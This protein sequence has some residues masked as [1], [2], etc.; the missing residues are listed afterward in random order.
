MRTWRGRH[1]SC[2]QH[3][4]LALYHAI[5]QTYRAASSPCPRSLGSWF[6]GSPSGPGTHMQYACRGR[7]CIPVNIHPRIPTASCDVLGSVGVVNALDLD[8]AG[9]RVG[10]V[11]ATEVA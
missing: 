6:R 5:L 7:S 1:R 10:V 9:L 3:V 4:S 2:L 8:E 11:P